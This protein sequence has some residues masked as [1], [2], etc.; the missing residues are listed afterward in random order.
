MAPRAA[1]ATGRMS[2]T[3]SN[4]AEGRL[5]PPEPRLEVGM[6]GRRGFTLIEVVIVMAIIAITLGLTGPR[7]GAGFGR[8][9]LD[10]SAQTV[11]RMVKLAR[12]EAERSERVQYVILTRKTR[13]VALINSD[14]AVLHQE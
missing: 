6:T 10:Q 7:I 3:G 8:L 14:L 9:N 11:R 13:S 4:L 12:L 5:S 1:K 2:S